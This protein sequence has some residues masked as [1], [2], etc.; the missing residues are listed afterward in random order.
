MNEKYSTYN[1]LVQKLRAEKQLL[2]E[3]ADRIEKLQWGLERLAG[4]YEEEH[5]IGERPQ[6]LRDLMQHQ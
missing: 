5:E 2:A 4:L 1:S 6:W 3:A